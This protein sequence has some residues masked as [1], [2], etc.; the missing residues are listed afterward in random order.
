MNL[1]ENI[2]RIR[3]MMGVDENKP[4]DIKELQIR[5]DREGYIHFLDTKNEVGYKYKL[6]AQYKH[7]FKGD[8]TEFIKV[9]SLDVTNRKIKYL[10]S[11]TNEEKEEILEEKT[12]QEILNNYSNEQDIKNILSFKEMGV[13]VHINLMFEYIYNLK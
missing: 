8:Q 9:L 7:P 13:D 4:S 2:E 11:N 6:V 5:V 3:E 12:A 10:D 1:R